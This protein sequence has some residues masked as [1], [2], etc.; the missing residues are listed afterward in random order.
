MTMD[1]REIRDHSQRIVV[2]YE[3][4]T[5]N[6][7]SKTALEGHLAGCPECRA[8]V[9]QQRQLWAVLDAWEVPPV[10]P[11]FEARLAAAWEAEQKPGW[12]QRWTSA[13]VLRAAFAVS[14]VCVTL[15]A[16]LLMNAPPFPSPSSSS[17]TAPFSSLERADAIDIEQVESILEELEMLEQWTSP[18]TPVGQTQAL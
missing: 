1:C 16:A 10:S 17:S 5:L 4:G 3:A 2:E 9:E 6:A 15:A 12:W 8:L 14:L 7:V 11:G 18:A 13:A